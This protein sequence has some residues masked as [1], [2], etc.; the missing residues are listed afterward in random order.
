MVSESKFISLETTFSKKSEERIF[1]THFIFD[2]KK[3][4]FIVKFKYF[5]YQRRSYVYNL[6]L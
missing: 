5:C 1:A 3:I 2:S 6:G 4:I